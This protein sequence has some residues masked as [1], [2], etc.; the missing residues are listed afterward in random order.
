MADPQGVAFEIHE[1]GD[2]TGE[3]FV[4]KF[5]AKEKLSWGDQMQADRYRRELLGPNGAEADI[6]TQ[7][8]AM[9]VSELSVRLSE[10]PD[11]WKSSRGGL[12]FADDNIVIVIWQKASDIRKEWLTRNQKKGDEAREKLRQASDA[13]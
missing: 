11:W 1:V 6:Q 12:D 3:L 4:G 10:A 7:N 8:R 5:R 9:M 13:K 2:D